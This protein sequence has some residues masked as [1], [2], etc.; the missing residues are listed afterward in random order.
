VE[1][2]IEQAQEFIQKYYFELRK[3][4]MKRAITIRKWRE[5]DRYDP[6]MEKWSDFVF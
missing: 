5:S 4:L 2:A 3:E 1:R 6:F